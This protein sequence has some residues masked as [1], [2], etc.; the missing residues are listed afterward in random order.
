MPNDFIK[1]YVREEP[2]GFLS[3]FWRSRQRMEFDMTEYPTNEHWFQSYK[4]KDSK[5]RSWIAQAPTAFAAM[6]AGRALRPHETISNWDQIKV[7]VMLDGLRTKFENRD[8]RC[9]LLET[10]NATLMED[11]PTDMFWG[12]TLPGS[13]NMLGKL[14]M[15][16]RNEIRAE[17]STR[18]ASHGA[19]L[20]EGE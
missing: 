13:A 8:L 19:M 3:N 15:Q 14:L 12:G 7:S 2:Y 1:F 20:F 10:G 4:A 18:N 17:Y 6:C 16:V 11:S 5:T 9:M